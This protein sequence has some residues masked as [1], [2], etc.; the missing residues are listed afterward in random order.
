MDLLSPSIDFAILCDAVQ[1]AGGKLHLVGGGWDN[2]FVSKFPARH[3][4]L[5]IGMRVRIPWSST[6]ETVQIHVDLIDED[7]TSVLPSGPLHHHVRARRNPA[8]EEGTDL[9]IVR[10]FTFN[11]LEF[12]HPG[13]YAFVLTIGDSVHRL[14]FT[15]RQR[16]AR[17]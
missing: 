3:H 17:E 12:P 8:M 15:V 13:S 2:L 9:G 16:P 4:T 5:G 7:G 11:N 1:A 6:D 14:G 10:A